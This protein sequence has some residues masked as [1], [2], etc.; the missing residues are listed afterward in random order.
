MTARACWVDSD[1][2]SRRLEH[3]MQL[4]AADRSL[5][6]RRMASLGHGEYTIA[7]ATRL[8][9]E[10]VRRELAGERGRATA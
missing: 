6:I 8:R 1:F 4:S 10:Y 5:A 7:A 3:F 2:D 9:V